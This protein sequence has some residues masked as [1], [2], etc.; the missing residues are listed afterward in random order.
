MKHKQTQQA[1]LC[2]D[3]EISAFNNRFKDMEN[4]YSTELNKLQMENI[5][6]REQQT[7]QAQQQWRTDGARPDGARVFKKNPKVEEETT[8]DEGDEIEEFRNVKAVPVNIP[9]KQ[10]QRKRQH[11]EEQH[12]TKRQNG[13]TEEENEYVTDIPKFNDA[14]TPDTDQPK[15]MTQQQMLKH[16][17]NTRM[18]ETNNKKQQALTFQEQLKAEA[19]ENYTK[20]AAK[21]SASLG[22]SRNQDINEEKIKQIIEEEEQNKEQQQNAEETEDNDLIDASLIVQ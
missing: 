4:K 5:Q 19:E 10:H 17:L 1:I 16:A 7:Q 21:I 12:E 18:I 14:P 9:K 2:K 8:E 6:L 20:D 22:L 15:K 3:S 13:P 11:N